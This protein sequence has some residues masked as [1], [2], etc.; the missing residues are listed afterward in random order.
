MLVPTINAEGEIGSVE[1]KNEDYYA[2]FPL[3]KMKKKKLKLV[4]LTEVAAT[5]EQAMEREIY[6]LE[7]FGFMLAK[8]QIPQIN[9]D[10][11]TTFPCV[12]VSVYVS[13]KFL[14]G[15]EDRPLQLS[16]YVMRF[17]PWLFS[18]GTRGIV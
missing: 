8:E 12:N 6:H 16:Q 7:D 11:I 13:E 3:E 17:S 14:E 15:V 2:R 5:T 18:Y 10:K 1:V 9:K 4:L